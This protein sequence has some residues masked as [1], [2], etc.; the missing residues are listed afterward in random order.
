LQTIFRG[1]KPHFP[2]QV[3]LDIDTHWKGSNQAKSAPRGR[4]PVNTKR[5]GGMVEV[6][7]AVTENH[8]SSQQW[9]L[10]RICSQ[11]MT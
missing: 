9:K 4:A 11:G 3:W 2:F 5:D 8:Y 10:R 6:D 7:L 1:L